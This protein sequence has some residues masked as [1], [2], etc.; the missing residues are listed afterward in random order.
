MNYK[1]L[2]KFVILVM[3]FLIC[4]SLFATTINNASPLIPYAVTSSDNQPRVALVLGGGGARG[5]AHLGVINVLEKAGVPVDLIVGTSI[6]SLVGA[7]Y[8]DNPNSAAVSQIL[9]NTNKKQLLNFSLFHIFRGPFSNIGIEDYVLKEIQAKQINNLKIKYVAVATDLNSGETVPLYSGQVDTAVAASMALPPFFPA[10]NVNGRTLI[11]G[12]MSDP[13]PVDVAKLYHPKIIIAVSIAETPPI[14]SH[15]V[16]AMDIYHRAQLWQRA[17][18]DKKSASG[19]DVYI[20]PDVG[21]TGTFDN[22]KEYLLVQNGEAA[23]YQALPQI[24]AL[25]KANHIPSR[26]DSV[27]RNLN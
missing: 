22:S 11:D 10:L 27:L 1:I 17:N 18:F 25:L 12:G 26:C 9:L 3:P 15:N 6:G 19:A 14:H 23:T 13:V 8:A 24:C 21:Q 16:F 2:C 7:L 5:A 20:H 4:S